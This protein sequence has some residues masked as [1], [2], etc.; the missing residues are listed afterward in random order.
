MSGQLETTLS[1]GRSLKVKVIRHPR[2]RTVR[3]SIR[4][5]GTVQLSAPS[6]TR[7][8]LLSGFVRD[9]EPWLR[10]HLP[11]PAEV[12]CPAE[13]ELRGIAE[14]WQLS[15]GHG[16]R[17]VTETPA[18]RLL[19]PAQ[20]GEP[21]LRQLERWLAQRARTELGAQLA[22][23]SSETRLPYRRLS[24]RNQRSR[25][26]SYSAAG[27]VS[28]NLKLLFLPP[29]MVRYV[30]VHELCHSLHLNHSAEFWNEVARHEPRLGELKA[31]MRDAARYV[32]DWLLRPRQR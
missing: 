18:G 25:W 5:D 10:Q 24:I 32:P 3:L 6:R 21:A 9:N 4:A 26:G 16:K 2:Y 7:A 31:T 19:V 8:A 15:Y 22:A 30:L 27:D 28:L 20:P 23:L 13:L 11:A 17:A 14:H 12:R 29:A 1:D